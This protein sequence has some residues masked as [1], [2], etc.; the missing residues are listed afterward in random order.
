MK[1]SHVLGLVCLFFEVLVV[2]FGHLSARM[3]HRAYDLVIPG[4]VLPRLTVLSIHAVWG[5]AAIGLALLLY[6]VSRWK[7]T[8]IPIST[9]LIFMLLNITLLMLV[10]W[11]V[12]L[13][14][15]LMSPLNAG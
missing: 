10:L 3:A 15:G 12:L 7:H 11:G 13:P 6:V 4:E 2:W 8:N 14:F 9:L 5:F 1:L